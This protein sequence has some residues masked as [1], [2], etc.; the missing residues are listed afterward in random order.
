MI[1]YANIPS[2]RDA[3][4]PNQL[5]R[6]SLRRPGA[7][8]GC[9]RCERPP[10]TACGYAASSTVVWP[11]CVPLPPWPL[12]SASGDSDADTLCETRDRNG[13]RPAPLPPAACG[14]LAHLWRVVF[15]CSS[16]FE[17]AQSWIDAHAEF[18]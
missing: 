1:L 13:L 17:A 15:V 16:N 6:S 7:P 18:H 11:T 10:D 14:R 2:L 8:A 9:S 12:P 3:R 4:A 5:L